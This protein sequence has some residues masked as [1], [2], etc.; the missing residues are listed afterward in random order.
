MSEATATL[1]PPAAPAKPVLRFEVLNG[2]HCGPDTYRRND[3]GEYVS[4]G[5]G[6]HYRKGE[7][8]ETTQDLSFLF[9]KDKDPNAKKFRRL[10]DTQEEETAE[11]LRAKRAEIDAKLAALENPQPVGADATIEAMTVEELRAF[12]ASEEIDLGN[13]KTKDAILKAIRAALVDTAAKTGFNS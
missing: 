13:A 2:T 7:I 4:N 5:D 9:D 3:N 1:A 10:Y 12:A 8:V 6:K 11:T